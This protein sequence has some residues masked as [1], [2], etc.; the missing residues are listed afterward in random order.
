MNS[1]QLLLKID[2]KFLVFYWLWLFLNFLI[3]VLIDAQYN[4]YETTQEAK[5]YIAVTFDYNYLFGVW[6]TTLLFG[7]YSFRSRHKLT[8]YLSIVLLFGLLVM[9]GG[10]LLYQFG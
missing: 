10:G 2:K 1:T 4:I 7:M 8:F 9:I 5:P 3:A 6:F